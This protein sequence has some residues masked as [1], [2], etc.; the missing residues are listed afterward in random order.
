MTIAVYYKNH[1][2]FLFLCLQN[3]QTCLLL[4]HHRQGEKY[5]L[6]WKA[7]RFFF[8]LTKE[9]HE[10]RGKIAT[11]NNT[12]HWTEKMQIC[13]KI[14]NFLFQNFLSLTLFELLKYYWKYFFRYI[15]SDNQIRSETR[16][17]YSTRL[18]IRILSK[19]TSEKIV[20]NII[21]SHFLSWCL[22]KFL[23]CMHAM[24]FSN[25]IDD[26]CWL[27]PNFRST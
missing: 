7:L 25:I 9:L 5:E 14:S 12:M 21:F 27:F 15:G 10:K 6:N 1:S 8:I 11:H 2:F 19:I 18:L 23:I 17:F 16:N 22:Q 20:S 13:Q 3:W 24:N 26:S 4:A